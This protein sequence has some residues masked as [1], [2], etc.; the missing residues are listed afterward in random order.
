MICRGWYRRGIHSTE[1]YTE[2][3]QLIKVRRLG[4]RSASALLLL[5]HL[6]RL[7]DLTVDL[8]LDLLSLLKMLL[9]RTEIFINVFL[10]LPWV[11]R[12]GEDAL[13]SRDRFCVGRNSV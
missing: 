4:N 13:P 3:V 5:L 10:R 1:R 7:L 2:S 6:L 11:Y 12:Q 8:G 9:C